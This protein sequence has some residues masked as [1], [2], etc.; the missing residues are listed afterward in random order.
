MQIK[1]N[2]WLVLR[3]HL[4]RT[5]LDASCVKR[6]FHSEYWVPDL[7]EAP[8]ELWGFFSQP[9]Q[10]FFPW[11]HCFFSGVSCLVCI[12]FLR[13]TLCGSPEFSLL[14][15][16]GLPQL[17][18]LC[19]QLSRT[20]GFVFIVPTPC[21]ME[22]LQTAQPIA[23]L[24]SFVS[25]LLGLYFY[26]LLYN[27][28]KLQFLMFCLVCKSLR[29]DANSMP[30]CSITEREFSTFKINLLKFLIYLFSEIYFA[31]KKIFHTYFLLWKL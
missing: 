30:F 26:Y 25:L 14:C 24:I 6:S 28:W 16:L 11:L 21:S 20:S 27:I 7:A 4:L 15:Y 22:T 9:F 23:W 29:W 5:L 10:G 17:W 3:Q 2:L 1:Q 31:R 13:G 8:H 19:S 12:L 18:I